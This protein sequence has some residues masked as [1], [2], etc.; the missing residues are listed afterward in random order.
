MHLTATGRFSIKSIT[1]ALIFFIKLTMYIKDE[2]NQLYCYNRVR[3][4]ER[5]KENKNDRERKN[6]RDNWKR[7]ELQCQECVHVSC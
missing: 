5:K 1:F 7:E 3:E 6:E 4:R 2:L